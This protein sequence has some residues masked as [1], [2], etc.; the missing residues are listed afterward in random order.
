[1][2]GK[3]V[4]VTCGIN[5]INK[6]VYGAMVHNNLFL[7]FFLLSF[8]LFIYLLFFCWMNTYTFWCS[9]PVVVTT[10]SYTTVVV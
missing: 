2:G 7:F 6:D 10:F 8:S 9:V 3:S 1:M 5:T 4:T